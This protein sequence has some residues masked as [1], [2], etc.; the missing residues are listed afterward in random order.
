MFLLELQS[1]TACA[2]TFSDNCLREMTETWELYTLQRKVYSGRQYWS[3]H[4]YQRLRS[5]GTPLGPGSAIAAE[6]QAR[7]TPGY[8]YT[9][10]V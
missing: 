7:R 8:G 4:Y 1:E 10:K 2:G 9:H 6:L 5:A 3:R